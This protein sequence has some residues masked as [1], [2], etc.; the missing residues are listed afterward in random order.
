MS[1]PNAPGEPTVTHLSIMK[2]LTFCAAHRLMGHEGKCLN[3]HGHNYRVEIFVSGNS[4]DSVGRI[5]DFSV[6]NRLFKNWIET[7]WDHA[8]LLSRDDE[9]A[10]DAVSQIEPNKLYLLPDNPTA[11]N[12]ARYLIE[13]IAP[14]LIATIPNY[15]VFVSKVVLWETDTACAEACREARHPR[16][17]S[18][19]QRSQQQ[20]TMK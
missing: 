16:R 11:E 19:Q 13:Q 10:I 3:L 14:A 9:G 4:T 8:V 17:L 20:A 2:Q 1:K 15:D 12:M 7:N 6:I 18:T 5:I